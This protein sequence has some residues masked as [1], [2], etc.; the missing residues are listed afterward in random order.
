[1]IQPLC[2]LAAV[3]IN[4]VLGLLDYQEAMYLWKV[5]KFDFWVW[6]VACMT[7]MFLGVEI[8]LAISVGVSLLLVIY[9]SA[10]PHTAQLGRLPGTAVYRNVK[11][12]PE[13]E[14]YDGIVMVRIDAPIYFANSQYVRDKLRKYEVAAERELVERGSKIGVKFIILEL[15]PVSH[16]DTS[17]LHILQ[18]M[19]NTYKGRGIQL[20]FCNPS[21]QVMER[22][23]VSGLAEEVG[24]DHFF[25]AVQDAVTFCLNQMD[26]ASERETSVV[27][28]DEDVD[29]EG[30]DVASEHEA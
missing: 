14:R 16:V 27:F 9:E 24:R 19:C 26:H 25:V 2:V 4:G 8:G 20:C 22:F 30:Q 10:Y 3:V 15:S 29:L 12:Y 7:T 13:T 23:L 5:Y 21:A 28:V 17:A 11:Q 18:D 1:M 6:M